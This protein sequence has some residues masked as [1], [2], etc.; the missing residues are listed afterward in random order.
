MEDIDLK[1]GEI[2]FETVDQ[3]VIDSINN[4]DSDTFDTGKLAGIY[5]DLW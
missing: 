3:I 5:N 2:K 4:I 1:P